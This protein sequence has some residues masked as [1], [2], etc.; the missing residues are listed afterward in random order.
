MGKIFA[1]CI[2]TPLEVGVVYGQRSH[3]HRFLGK[4]CSACQKLN[5]KAANSVYVDIQLSS[6]TNNF[7]HCCGCTQPI[8]L[9]NILGNGMQGNAKL[10]SSMWCLQCL[11]QDCLKVVFLLHTV[12]SLACCNF[13]RSRY[14]PVIGY[15]L[16]P[17]ILMN[18]L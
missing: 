2:T 8:P 4:D 12:S 16:G 3:V 15:F 13:C 6:K 14:L 11:F 17:M 5:E 10:Y 7:R 18:R 9:S 1:N